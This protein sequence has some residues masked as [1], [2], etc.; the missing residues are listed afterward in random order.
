MSLSQLAPVVMGTGLLL[1][2]LSRWIDVEYRSSVYLPMADD[3]RY[4]VFVAP[5]GLLAR[6]DNAAA[7]TAITDW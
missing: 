4:R 5:P 1:A 6:P 7:R 3:A 2:W